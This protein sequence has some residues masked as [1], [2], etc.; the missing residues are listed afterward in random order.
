MLPSNITY[1]Y[2]SNPTPPRPAIPF[3]LRLLRRIIAM[4][5]TYIAQTYSGEGRLPIVI[6][7]WWS[8]DRILHFAHG[9]AHE[10]QFVATITRVSN[11]RRN[12]AEARKRIGQSANQSQFAA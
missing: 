8:I 2:P 12:R 3:V 1:L 5:K 4:Y 11:V 6:P 10:P 9:G 7:E